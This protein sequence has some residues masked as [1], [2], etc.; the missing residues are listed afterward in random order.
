LAIF[1][2]LSRPPSAVSMMI[3]MPF[4]SG[5]DLILVSIS[6]PSMTGIVMSRRM[7]SGRSLLAM[8]SPSTPL[9]ASR[10]SQSK[11]LKALRTMIRTVLESSTVST[12]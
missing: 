6:T 7:M 11:G 1:S 12:L 2:T 5:S 10:I 8:A 9:A 3:G 4:N